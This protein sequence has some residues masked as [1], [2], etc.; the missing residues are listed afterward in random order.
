MSIRAILSSLRLRRHLG[1]RE[2]QMLRSSALNI[3][4]ELEI[5]GGCNVQYALNPD[6]LSTVLLRSIR[7]SA[8]VLLWHPRRLAIRLPRFPP[9]WPW[10]TLD[11]I[12]NAITKKTYVV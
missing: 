11:E 6:S 4:D 12:P 5:T 1:D 8:G 7:V 9:S 10:D 3:I 2:Y